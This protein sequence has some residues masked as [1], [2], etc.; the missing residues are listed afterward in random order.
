MPLPGSASYNEFVRVFYRGLASLDVGLLDDAKRNF[1]RATELASNEPAAWANL[2]LAYLRAGEYPSATSAADK[3][4]SLVPDNARVVLLRAQ[5]DAAAGRTGTGLARF[6]QAAALAP[7]DVKTLYALAQALEAVG[8]P[9]SDADAQNAYDRV[10]AIQASN[11]PV[12]LDK[13]RL[14]AKRSDGTALRGTVTDIES[15]SGQWPAT[16]RDQ[17]RALRMATDESRFADAARSTA[18]I[19]NVLLREPTFRNEIEAVKVP[20]EVIAEPFRTSLRLSTPVF[21]PAP[22]DL[23]LKYSPDAA[24][25]TQAPAVSSIAA[26]SPDGARL[27]ILFPSQSARSLMPIDLNRDFRVDVVSAAADGL[28]FFEQRADGSFAPVAVENRVADFFKGNFR[29]VWTA[30]LDMDGDLDLVG[31]IDGAP[32]R[33]LRNNGDGTW[34]PI[35]TFASIVGLRAFAWGDLDHDGS[36]DAA[37]LD[38]RG[39]LH[40]FENV[41]GG[42][43]R[44]M[45]APRIEHALALTVSDIDHDGALDLVTMDTNG[46]I[47]QS[48]WNGDRWET[49]TLVTWRARLADSPGTYRLFVEDLDNNGALDIAASGN[50]NAQIWLSAGPAT[51]Q[52]LQGTPQLTIVSILDLDGDGTLDLAGVADGRPARL[53][54]RGTRGYHWQVI[55]ARAQDT[56]GDQ[57]INAFGVGGNV[58]IRSG[59]LTQKQLLTGAPAHFGLGLQAEVDVVRIVWPNGVVQVDFDLKPDQAVLAEQR[60]KGSC[61]WVFADNGTGLQF[62]TDFLWRSPLGL[63]INAQDTAG[64]SQTEDWVRIRGD[65]LKAKD[66][67]YDL[68]ITAELWET[69]FIDMVSLLSVDHPLDVDVFVDERFS[70]KAPHLEVHAVSN[71]ASIARAWDEQGH[72]VGARVFRRDGQYVDTF[73]LGQFQ[74]V[75]N[76]HWVE[77]ELDREIPQD[78]QLW[79]IGNGWI[80]PTDSSINVAIGQGGQAKPHGLSLDARDASGQWVTIAPDLGFPAGKNKTIMVDLG[81][82]PRAGLTNA[83]R[84]RLRTNLEIYWDWLATAEE[85]PG[86]SLKT[87]RLPASSAE[88]RYRGFSQTHLTRRDA[89]EAPIYDQLANVTPRW[90]DLAGYYTRFGDVKELVDQVDDRYVIMNAGDELRLRFAAGGAL[91]SG[92]AR[93][94][95]LIGDGWVKDGDYNTSFSKTVEP[96]P[97]H[98]WP[99][100]NTP[101]QADLES[102]PIYRRYPA[103][104]LRYHTRYVAPAQFLRGLQ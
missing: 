42:V 64:V 77:F 24:E 20:A 83:R 35:Q 53:L 41:Q 11:V 62:V 14:A 43:F 26:F 65:Q 52:E 16:A 56:A 103:D 4:T 82:V 72:D 19:R 80:Y 8:S 13:A 31:G 94:F 37:L 95:V 60:L 29:D 67:Y 84:L 92:W 102:D 7:R 57:R 50:N 55:R 66:G 71:P 90:R 32:P 38:D 69:H 78:R 36:P 9:Q 3:A 1:V 51:F 49:H 17:I 100:Y 88:L 87:V 27:P 45:P 54:G 75:T 97:S 79:L 23:A 33:V 76:E 22:P 86:G 15:R 91:P 101:P 21:V 99:S 74:G 98:D 28:Q 40:V 47:Q 63:R 73:P 25:R 61:P 12:L 44:D 18:I 39:T 85:R 68:R 104:W 59:Q 48:T 6:R 89:P 96:L 70:A 5:I 93:D 10:L 2:S 81:S 34:Q 46:H 30:D 58:E